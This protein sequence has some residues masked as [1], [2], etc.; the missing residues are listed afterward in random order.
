M[1]AWARVNNESAPHDGSQDR[2]A[3]RSAAEP[4]E[5]PMSFI[6]HCRPPATCNLQPATCSCWEP[7]FCLC[8]SRSLGRKGTHTH[9]YFVGLAAAAMLLDQT[10]QTLRAAV[11]LSELVCIHEH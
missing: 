7:A 11:E 6:K 4:A 5:P 1:Q 3:A 8:S 10:Y 2:T 9:S